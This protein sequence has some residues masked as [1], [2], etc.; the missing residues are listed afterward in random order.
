MITMLR[1]VIIGVN[2]Q[3]GW[4]RDAHVPAVQGL[5]GLTL[6]AVAT[7]SQRT[8]DEAAHAFGVD[9]AYGDGLT[10]IADPEID[11]V[12]V[13]TRVQGHRDLMLAAIVAGKHVYSEWPLGRGSAES[14]EMARA[15]ETAGIHH[16]IGLQLRQSP[17]VRAA[18]EVIASGALGRLLA[19]SCHRRLRPRGARAV[20]LP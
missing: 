19:I 13:A 16:A 10:L 15:A 4:A 5:D 12:T 7:N 8:A 14:G 1:V 20:R 18:R 17:A 2:A 9:K 3:S 11:L 6:C